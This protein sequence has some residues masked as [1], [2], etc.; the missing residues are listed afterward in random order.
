MGRERIRKV[1]LVTIWIL[2]VAAAVIFRH[3]ARLTTNLKLSVWLS[4]GRTA[5]YFITYIVWGIL[6]RRHVVVRSVKRW[7]S[8]IV[9]LMLFWMIVRQIPKTKIPW[10]WDGEVYVPKDTEPVQVGNF[11]VEAEYLPIDTVYPT[12]N[13]GYSKV[14]KSGGWYYILTDGDVSEYSDEDGGLAYEGD[15]YFDFDVENI[16]GDEDGN[17]YALGNGGPLARWGTE[18]DEVLLNY[19]VMVSLHPS[20]KKAV[21]W[22]Y[23]NSITEYDFETGTNKERVIDPV[24]GINSVSVTKDYQAVCGYKES[25]T[26]LN[27]YDNNWNEVMTISST[28]TESGM[29]E[30]VSAFEQTQNGWV[31]FDSWM[32]NVIFV[33]FDSAILKEVSYEELFGTLN[34][35]YVN[36]TCMDEEG[37]VIVAIT[38][39][40]EATAFM[41][42]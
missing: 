3:V 5:I 20:G 29:L 28:D 11:T 15:V 26:L 41:S 22:S 10:Y 1:A 19:C 42:K 13:N 34:W 18:E 21:G 4:D 2:A 33:G 14:A 31:I 39:Q 8:A 23:S 9:F 40:R 36:G 7:L 27:I 12:F 6:L 37:N 38:D 24:E 25:E 17:L 16:F 30:G 35:P 32:E